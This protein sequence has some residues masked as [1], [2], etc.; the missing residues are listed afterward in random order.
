MARNS[1]HENARHVNINARHLVGV[2]A[3]RS[4]VRQQTTTG[5]FLLSGR[6]W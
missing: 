6:L 5:F 3:R 2:D 4:E 1:D